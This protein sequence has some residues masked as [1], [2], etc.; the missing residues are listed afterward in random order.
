VV[1]LLLLPGLD[2][3]DVLFRP[4][5]S[6]LPSWIRPLVVT[7]PAT[8]G[9]RYEDLMTIVRSA[10]ADIPECWVLGWSFSGPLAIMLAAEQ[11]HKVRGV[12]LSA[13]FVRAPRRSLVWVRPAMLTPV[14]WTIRVVRRSPLLFKPR[15]D[16][17]RRDKAEIW[18]RVSAPTLAARVRTVL[19]TDVRDLL[20]GLD[21]PVV[22]LAGE[23][24]DVVPSWNADDVV[25]ALPSTR[26]ETIAGAHMAMYSNPKAAADVITTAIAAR[27]RS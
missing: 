20:A 3:T 12:I 23:G 11:P 22:Y 7:Y 4:L 8:R 26:V 9:T 18:A 25:K 14:I 2:G 1:T 15:V 24:D 6:A 27:D 16:R 21:A 17:L 13:S 5:L 10:V 19:R